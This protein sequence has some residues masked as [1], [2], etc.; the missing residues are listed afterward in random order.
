MKDP[1][2]T[3]AKPSF[4]GRH[5]LGMVIFGSGIVI[6]LALGIVPRVLWPPAGP[7]WMGNSY[8]AT[9]VLIA[10]LAFGGIIYT[11]ILQSREL[12]LQRQELEETRSEL[13]RSADAQQRTDSVLHLTAYLNVVTALIEANEG[14]MRGE[15][16]SEFRPVRQETEFL[17]CILRAAHAKLNKR[18]ASDLMATDVRGVI[19]PL[20]AGRGRTLANCL[21]DWHGQRRDDCAQDAIARTGRYLQWLAQVSLADEEAGGPL[22]DELRR[23]A[24]TLESLAA[25]PPNDAEYERAIGLARELSALGKSWSSAQ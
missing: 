5:W 4:L 1:F 11:I 22:G 2:D 6:W 21:A 7:H 18:V 17:R 9:N 19:G 23:Y 15:A 20:L 25:A 16:G 10:A 24:S 3:T 12:A 8:E 13:A 14:P